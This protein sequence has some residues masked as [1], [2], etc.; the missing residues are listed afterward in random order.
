MA[1]TTRLSK[2]DTVKWGE[3]DSRDWGESTSDDEVGEVAVKAVLSQASPKK[4]KR[5]QR[6]VGTKKEL[7]LDT[8]VQGVFKKRQGAA[9][10]EDKLLDEATRFAEA[11]R[12]KIIE[13]A[14]RTFTEIVGDKE[15]RFEAMLEFDSPYREGLS[16]DQEEIAKSLKDQNNNCSIMVRRCLEKITVDLP[17]EQIAKIFDLI[18]RSLNWLLINKAKFL[19]ENIQHMDLG[20]LDNINAFLKEK[21]EEVFHLYKS[22]GLKCANKPKV[23]RKIVVR[24]EKLILLD[25]RSECKEKK[26]FIRVLTGLNEFVFRFVE[27]DLSYRDVPSYAN[28]VVE[29][30]EVII[31]RLHSNLKKNESDMFV[32]Q[33]TKVLY[34]CLLFSKFNFLRHNQSKETRHLGQSKTLSREE[35]EFQKELRINHILFLPYQE[36]SE[37][38]SDKELNQLTYIQECVDACS[39][40][41]SRSQELECIRYD[42]EKLPVFQKII[43]SFLHLIAY[44]KSVKHESYW[45]P[46]TAFFCTPQTIRKETLIQD[47]I[48]SLK[49]EQKYYEDFYQ[50]IVNIGNRI[51][52]DIYSLF[53]SLPESDRTKENYDKI[54]HLCFLLVDKLLVVYFNPTCFLVNYQSRFSPHLLPHDL[55]NVIWNIGAKHR[56]VIGGLT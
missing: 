23:F 38:D 30:P 27:G 51:I 33:K 12:R 53:D 45:S 2:L 17:T 6:L 5:P 55:G 54:N 9:A 22:L 19:S 47:F 18:L 4:C 10:S 42:F 34:N 21:G 26:E 16:S 44:C 32:T 13:Q 31:A 11:E 49:Y 25:V 52:F 37:K 40:L 3:L 29:I 39:R 41:S 14:K 35:V 36:F 56:E 48:K 7:S 46:L 20:K 1:A 8:K 43:N 28:P 50:K 24:E 15:T